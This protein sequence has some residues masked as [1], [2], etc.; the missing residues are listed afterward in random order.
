MKPRFFT[1]ALSVTVLLAATACGFAQ[2][3]KDAAPPPD[4]PGKH[5][6]HFK[7]L[8][9]RWN[10]EITTLQPAK[11]KSKGTA[12]F[13]VLMGGR[14][15][16][17]Q[18]NGKMMGAPFQGMGITGYDNGKKKYTGTWIDNH[19]TGIMT[20]EGT[21]DPKTQTLTEIGTTSTPM[22]SMKLKMV[23]KYLSNDKFL[24]TMSM[25]AGGSEQ[26]FMEV[27][28]TRMKGKRKPR[29]SLKRDRPRNNK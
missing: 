16:Q 9:G 14:F 4:K 22:G 23:S 11:A 18:F 15:L 10:C 6:A 28:Y 24:F 3:K 2:A 26:K 27:T 5:H 25:M 29:K 17:Q 19:N 20:T 21:Y 1:A 8:A 7:R 12:V 13:R